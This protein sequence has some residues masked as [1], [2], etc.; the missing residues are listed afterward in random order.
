MDL[1]E[2]LSTTADHLLHGSKL[3]INASL[4]LSVGL[5]LDKMYEKFY[6]S[7]DFYKALYAKQGQDHEFS[8]EYLQE[9]YPE[10]D[11]DLAEL[12]AHL[13]DYRRMLGVDSACP[14]GA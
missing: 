8:E 3:H 11:D 1:S 7:D 12:S 9:V 6:T 10:V 4:P 13:E 14:N 5:T 2:F